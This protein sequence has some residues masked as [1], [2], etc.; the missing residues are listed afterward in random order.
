MVRRRAPRAHDWLAGAGG[1][2]VLTVREVDMQR[3]QVSTL[4]IASIM[5]AFWAYTIMDTL[6]REF[7]KEI[8]YIDLGAIFFLGCISGAALSLGLALR[9]KQPDAS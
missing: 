6:I 9:Q 2:Q 7:S 4:F 5:A 8:T 1:Q 3:Y